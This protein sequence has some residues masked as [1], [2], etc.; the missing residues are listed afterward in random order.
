[1]VYLTGLEPAASGIGIPRSI[2]MG[3]RYITQYSIAQLSRKWYTKVSK[4][5]FTVA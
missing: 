4:N 2:Q 1:M 5:V 3:Y